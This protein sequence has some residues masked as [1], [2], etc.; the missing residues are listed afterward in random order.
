MP[1][2]ASRDDRTVGADARIEAKSM[3]MK[4][5]LT[6][7][8]ALLGLIFSSGPSIARSQTAGIDVY[9]PIEGVTVVTVSTE[10]NDGAATAEPRSVKVSNRIVVI[11]PDR[12]FHR[13][14][15]CGIGVLY[16]W[17]RKSCGDPLYTP[18]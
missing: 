6:T 3:C 4:P 18:Y 14:H 12:R 11:V 1:L 17:R 9:S 5:T 7:V 13:S 10:V 2:I 15:R 8:V 16:P